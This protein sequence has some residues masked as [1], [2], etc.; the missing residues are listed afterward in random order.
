MRAWL[1]KPVRPA[2]P[3]GKLFIPEGKVARASPAFRLLSWCGNSPNVLDLLGEL[4]MLIREELVVSLG[5]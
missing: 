5:A 1:W 2:I 3:C 4:N